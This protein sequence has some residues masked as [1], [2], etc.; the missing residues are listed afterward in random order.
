M[1]ES[2]KNMLEARAES[3]A[4]LSSFDLTKNRLITEKMELEKL[5][6]STR[7]VDFAEAATRFQ[8]QQTVLEASM[9][10]A[11]RILQTSILSYL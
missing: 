3:G 11:S 8:V 2:Q 7:D 9:A 6:S 4:R 10:V 5:V 1:D